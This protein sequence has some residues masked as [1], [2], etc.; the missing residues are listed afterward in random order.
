MPLLALPSYLSLK[1]SLGPHVQGAG[2]SEERTMKVWAVVM[3]FLMALVTTAC[4]DDDA[5]NPSSVDSS[6]SVGSLSS[7]AM[8][9]SSDASSSSVGSVSSA[10]ASTSSTGPALPGVYV[11]NGDAIHRIDLNGSSA[12]AVYTATG[13]S[14]N[15]NYGG[16]VLDKSAKKIYWMEQPWT[17]TRKIRRA[18]LDGANVEDVHVFADQTTDY[19][20]IGVDPAANGKVYWFA[21]QKSSLYACDKDGSNAVALLANALGFLG[22]P[23]RPSLDLANG[24]IVWMNHKVDEFY[25][26]STN[27]GTT[28]DIVTGT[29]DTSH[30][31]NNLVVNPATGK[32]YWV[33]YWGAG[34]GPGYFEMADYPSGA[35]AKRI[36]TN[37]GT[38]ATTVAEYIAIDP[39]ADRVW[40]FHRNASGVVYLKYAKGDGTG[41]T[42]TSISGYNSSM[43]IYNE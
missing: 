31:P 39:V 25:Y 1:D 41:V 19:K 27:G 17:G 16:L 38:G 15:M 18:D 34:D 7:G 5:T 28:S 10:V 23:I 11:L 6:V 33:S 9:T 35:N 14:Q 26:I 30:S 8:S 29:T 42:A 37:G 4:S 40:Y 13:G 24:R 43:V 3:V 12:A 21:F 36:D 22:P 20:L 2:H 32:M